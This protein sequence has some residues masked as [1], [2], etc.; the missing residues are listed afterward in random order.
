MDS[1]KT[2]QP[3]APGLRPGNAEAE[4]GGEAG[5]PRGHQADLPPENLAAPD[6]D[7]ET[8]SSDEDEE[9]RLPELT[10]ETGEPVSNSKSVAPRE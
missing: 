1:E 5:S 3:T 7:P 10:E 6:I 4:A 9:G 8:A 2:E